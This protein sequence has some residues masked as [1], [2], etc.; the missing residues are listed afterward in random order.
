MLRKLHNNNVFLNKLRLQQWRSLFQA[1]MPE[2]K[3]VLS[4]SGT[5]DREEAK[6]LQ[7]KGELLEY[8]IEELTTVDL[9][10]LWRKPETSRPLALRQVFA[11][12]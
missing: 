8:S 6:R 12:V 1:K 2:A 5:E 7:D 11:R 9:G 3:F 10:V 4:Q